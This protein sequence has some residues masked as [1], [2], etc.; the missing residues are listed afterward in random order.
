MR[1]LWIRLARRDMPTW[2]STGG[3]VKIRLHISGPNNRGKEVFTVSAS[4]IELLQARQS[5]RVVMKRI[6]SD[7]D[8]FEGI[9]NAN[10]GSRRLHGRYCG[11]F[12]RDHQDLP[13][14]LQIEVVGTSKYKNLENE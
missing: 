14:R 4:V 9:W 2:S 8:E 11:Y 5:R 13:G 10:V 6:K 1:Y 3:V 12:R 7:G